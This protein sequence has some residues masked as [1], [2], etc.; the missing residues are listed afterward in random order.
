MNSFKPGLVSKNYEVAKWASML[1]SKISYL[2]VNNKEK[3]LLTIAYHWFVSKYGGL[4]SCILSLRRHNNIREKIIEIML[5][6]GINSF[7]DLFTNVLKNESNGPKDFLL[8]ITDLFVPMI[9][10]EVSA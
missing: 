7:Y 6:F 2:I 9:N 4:H 5:H 3:K 1:L 8:T 10:N